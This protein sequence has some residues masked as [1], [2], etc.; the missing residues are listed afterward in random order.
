MLKTVNNLYARWPGATVVC[1]ASG[2][3]LDYG[4]YSDVDFV[5]QVHEGG[6][7]RVIVANREFKTAPWADI[8]YMADYR[9]WLEY[10]KS[11]T[12]IFK[13]EGWTVDKEAAKRFKLN[14]IERAFSEGY[15]TIPNTINTGQNSGFQ[16]V[17]LAAYFGASRIVMLGYDMQ[18]TKGREHHYGRHSGNLANGKGFHEWLPKLKPLLSDLKT[19]GIDVINATRETAIPD[20]WA[21]RMTVEEIP[22]S[23]DERS[24]SHARSA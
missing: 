8:C 15:S 20:K 23:M 4:K 24:Q 5:R 13:G 14:H 3:S 6:G 9:C 19:Y 7:C 2:P 18:R 10:I 11:Y 16:M 1:I 22:W 21:R 17:H 12:E